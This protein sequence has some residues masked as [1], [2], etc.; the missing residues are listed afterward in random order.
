MKKCESCHEQHFLFIPG[1]DVL[2]A[3]MRVEYTCP[4]D[5]LRHE[6]Q[7]GEYDW[8]RVDAAQPIGSVL[9]RVL[10]D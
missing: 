7:V 5:R 8:N 1:L 2:T 4:T 6:I 9:A 10:Q 3:G